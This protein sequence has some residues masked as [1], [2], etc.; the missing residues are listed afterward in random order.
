MISIEINGQKVTCKEGLTIL[1][2]A[3]N[4]GI[5][6]PTLCYHEALSPYGACRLCLVEILKGSRIGL[7][8]SCTYPVEE[9]LVVETD[10]ERIRKARRMIVELLLA[11]CPG[12]EIIQKLASEYGVEKTRFSL[13]KE[14]CILCGLCVRV[15]NEIIK[16]N[17]I[18]FA[19]RGAKRIVTTPF[20]LPS[21]YCLGCGACA[22]I[23][24]TGA[25]KITEIKD[26]R[27]INKWKTKLEMKK[28][29]VCGK[30]FIPIKEYKFLRDELIKIDFPITLLSI[31]F[32]CRK[33]Q[34]ADKLINIKEFM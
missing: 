27:E 25:I 18:G 23:C 24:P 17:S 8:S 12:V 29:D 4:I 30:P 1:D 5:F 10:N 21:D 31:C 28:C 14:D 7:E 13:E 3:K 26:T 34:S 22:A 6:I 20:D 15:C 9:N 33:K 19:N 32:D 16:Q 11:R 2:V